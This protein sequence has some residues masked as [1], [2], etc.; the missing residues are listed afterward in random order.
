MTDMDMTTLR[1]LIIELKDSGMTFQEVADVLEK[2][3]GIIRTRQG[4]NG[5]YKRAK[6]S[7]KEDESKQRVVCDIINLYCI[8]DSAQQVFN[9]LQQIGVNVSYRQVLNVINN[10]TS[11]IESVRQTIIANLEAQIESLTDIRDAIR[12]VE[13]KGI[14]VSKKKFSEYF[15]LAC[16]HYIRQEVVGELSKIYRLT[17]NKDMVKSLGQQFNIGIKTSDLR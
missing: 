3:Y 2:Q 13:Y 8:C 14:T 7:L 15:E 5:I 9:K 4:I 11:Y 6:E 10:E 17:S 1:T 16:K 12:L